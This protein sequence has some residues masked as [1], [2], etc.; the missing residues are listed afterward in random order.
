MDTLGR[1]AVDLRGAPFAP[2]R[3]VYHTLPLPRLPAN[4]RATGGADHGP[5]AGGQQPADEACSPTV[6]RRLPQD[7][8]GGDDLLLQ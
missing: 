6:H 5:P 7:V 3:P 8:G 2:F 4:N 1:R